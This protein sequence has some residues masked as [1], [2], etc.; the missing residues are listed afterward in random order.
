[1]S[2]KM[3]KSKIKF[4]YPYIYTELSVFLLTYVP[5]FIFDLF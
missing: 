4:K 5:Q 2:I 1:M 3:T